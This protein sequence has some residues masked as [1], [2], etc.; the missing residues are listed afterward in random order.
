MTCSHSEG[1][2]DHDIVMTRLAVSGEMAECKHD[3]ISC[4]EEA[5]E[6]PMPDDGW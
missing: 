3:T 5:A 4:Q 1:E 6:F 2:Y